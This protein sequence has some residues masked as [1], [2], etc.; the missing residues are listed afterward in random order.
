MKIAH[1]IMEM[2]LIGLLSAA[3]AFADDAAGSASFAGSGISPKISAGVEGNSSSL[4]G[5]PMRTEEKVNSKVDVDARGTG[6][7]I[8]LSLSALDKDS[9]GS[10]SRSEFGR[11][12]QPAAVFDRIDT[13]GNGIL[14]PV[15][16]DT[17]NNSSNRI[18]T[19]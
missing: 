4:S 12:N 2:S 13:D 8:I 18:K 6:R 7:G 19:R 1:K 11:S 5:T 16:L 15:E 9:N 14:S 17:Y 10:I 3:P